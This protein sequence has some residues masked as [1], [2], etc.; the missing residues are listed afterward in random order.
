M[1]PRT[2]LSAGLA[3]ALLGCGGV[4]DDLTTAESAPRVVRRVPPPTSLG[5]NASDAPPAEAN[6]EGETTATQPS[7]GE[8]SAED[9]S[10]AELDGL[11]YTDLLLRDL[12]AACGNCHGYEAVANDEVQGGFDCVEDITCSVRLGFII[13][14][15]SSQS[16]LIQV[17]RDQSMPPPGVQPRPDSSL[18]EAWAGLIDNPLFW[19]TP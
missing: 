9:G 13:P 4:A 15:R 1:Q 2:T 5:P 17:M 18:I 12:A 6:D 19:P 11:P 14:L 8:V 16:P 3:L 10:N 7:G